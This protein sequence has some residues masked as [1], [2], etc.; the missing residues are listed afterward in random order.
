MLIEYV[1]IRHITAMAIH[2]VSIAISPKITPSAAAC[3]FL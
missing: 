3:S 2:I 1:G